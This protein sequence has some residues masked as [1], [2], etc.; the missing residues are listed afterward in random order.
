VSS[1][2]QGLVPRHDM[3]QVPTARQFPLASH[4]PLLQTVFLGFTLSHVPRPSTLYRQDPQSFGEHFFVPLV[5]A[6]SVHSHWREEHCESAVQL[7]GGSA[8]QP[9]MPLHE[10]LPAQAPLSVPDEMLPVQ[11]TPASLLYLHCA[12][13]TSLQ[14]PLPEQVAFAQTQDPDA[15]CVPTPQP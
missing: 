13:V 12:Q 4:R 11:L 1:K 6:A 8:P 7:A 14:T 9:P 3:L 10:L 5:Q 2:S 15:H